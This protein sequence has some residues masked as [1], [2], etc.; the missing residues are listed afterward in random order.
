[1]A[2]V[3]EICNGA[4]HFLGDEAITSLED[5][6][7]RAILCKAFYPFVRD[8]VLRSHPWR[9]AM[10][11][12]HCAL[13]VAVPLFG[14][15]CQYQL[16]SDCLRVVG[17]EDEDVSWS[18]EGTKLLTD[19]SNGNIVYVKR[20]TDPGEYDEMLVLVI[21]LK[22]AMLLASAITDKANLIEGL[23]N[24]YKSVVQETKSVSAQEG[25]PQAFESNVLVDVR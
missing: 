22:M 5:N 9:C 16:P 7:N 21:M 11:R 1:M 15:S 12:Y 20:I 6:T 4:L 17:I 18:V 10:V 2:S 8:Y 23:E 14:F 3:V 13:L 19:S 25:S 24:L